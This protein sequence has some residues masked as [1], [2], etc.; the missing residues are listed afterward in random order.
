LGLKLIQ[1]T[2]RQ[3]IIF[4][5]TFITTNSHSVMDR[6]LLGPSTS[7]FEV[8]KYT[9][10]S[11]SVIP[12]SK[13][14]LNIELDGDFK[15]K[16]QELEEFVALYF[17]KAKLNFERCAKPDQ[18]RRQVEEILAVEGDDL[19]W[20][21]C[22]DDHVF[23]D[24]ETALWERLCKRLQGLNN[25]H[26]YA[27]LYFSHWPE[28]LA[29][30]DPTTSNFYHPD[31]KLMCGN[32]IESSD[33]YFINS[34]SNCDSIQVVNKRLLKF[35]WLDHDYGDIF[36]PRTDLTTFVKSPKEIA[37]IIPRRE[38]FRHYDGYSHVAMDPNQ[39]PPLQIPPGFFER[40]IKINFCGTERRAGWWNMDPRVKNYALVDPNGTD[41]RQMIED[42]PLFWK[43][44][45]SKIE[46]P[47]D[48]NQEELVLARNT[49]VLKTAG[50]KL[51][52][53]T[54]E[55]AKE[56]GIA[57]RRVNN[58]I[59]LPEDDS[60]QTPN[61]VDYTAVLRKHTLN[62]APLISVVILEQSKGDY[63]YHCI[64]SLLGSSCERKTY[65]VALVSIC[66]WCYGPIMK[67]ADIAIHT[68]QFSN[69]A[70]GTYHKNIGYNA[71][72]SEVSGEYLLLCDSS[73][74]F[75]QNFLPELIKD[76]AYKFGNQEEAAWVVELPTSLP[77]SDPEATPGSQTYALL[78]RRKTI[79]ELGGFSTADRFI[80]DFGGLPQVLNSLMLLGVKVM[81]PSAFAANLLS[82]L[83]AASPKRS[84]MIEAS[85]KDRERLSSS[86]DL[87]Q[88]KTTKIL[89]DINLA[90][91][92]SKLLAG[93]SLPEILPELSASDSA[94]L[95]EGLNSSIR[96]LANQ[97][98]RSCQPITEA[99]VDYSPD[100]IELANLHALTLIMDKKQAEAQVLLIKSL[101]REPN[102]RNTLLLLALLEKS[103]ANE[104]ECNRYLM[105]ALRYYPDSKQF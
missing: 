25:E 100:S 70:Q 55:L 97:D 53:P 5:N 12:H 19:V 2:A 42:L 85:L 76:L 3:M 21:S 26:E 62:E 72:L 28:M 40:D 60:Y 94:L 91:L 39:C 82:D 18:W 6:G 35:W 65:E 49:A 66:D 29:Y 13:A 58:H 105:T 50:A 83:E 54:A 9:L 37:C 27:S 102:N 48:L 10:A 64:Q 11:M 15:N 73:A 80:G 63:G 44:H 31:H 22:N 86:L 96:L 33:D 17:P 81:L 38:Q 59:P 47:G 78:V 36:M 4:L 46:A 77:K 89:L 24:Y 92:V 68:R 75:P 32:V 61:A 74:S 67:M 79:L 34:W 90:Q 51:R 8:L 56:I 30:L 95:T 57:L 71:A 45:I 87:G 99:L 101:E 41:S 16:S 7:K 103:R 20:F 14:F 69:W 52:L 93:E 43:T 23:I 98:F 1:D 84:F 104:E 88:A